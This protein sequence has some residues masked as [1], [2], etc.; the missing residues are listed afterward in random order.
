MARENAESGVRCQWRAFYRDVHMCGITIMVH[1]GLII[2]LAC[3]TPMRY[4]SRFLLPSVIGLLFLTHLL[5]A[6]E[7]ASTKGVRFTFIE[8]T[9][10]PAHDLPSEARHAGITPDPDAKKGK[11]TEIKFGIVRDT[12]DHGALSTI[13]AGRIAGITVTWAETN[14]FKTQEQTESVVRRLLSAPA[15]SYQSGSY[16]QTYTFVVWSQR[17]GQPSIT[18]RVEHKDGKPGQLLLF[19]S[20]DAY[21]FAYQDEEAKWW[22]GQ[23]REGVQK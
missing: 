19:A 10:V 17:L 12:K 2:L 22:L 11:T 1:R 4:Q 3:I 23:W 18:V 6:E 15:G 13:V 14:R 8:P 20:G 5:L 16:C 7:A 9:I 21:L